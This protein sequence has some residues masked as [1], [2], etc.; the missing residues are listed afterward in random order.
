MCHAGALRVTC[1]TGALRDFARAQRDRLCRGWWAPRGG[2]VWTV[3]SQRDAVSDTSGAM[4]C[5]EA[6]CYIRECDAC[7]A[8][9]RS[10]LSGAM[11]HL[12]G[13][14]LTFML[15]QQLSPV[16]FLERSASVYPE[17]PAVIHG[18]G[19]QVIRHN[20]AEL[21]ERCRRLRIARTRVVENPFRRQKS[22]PLPP[23]P[24]HRAS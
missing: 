2:A 8:K 12:S 17:H 11:M 5:A 23:V 1:H 18:F 3:T 4:C 6:V 14:K 9:A 19:D 13:S 22:P 24:T 10:E 20:Y 21:A 7:D 15:G 16:S